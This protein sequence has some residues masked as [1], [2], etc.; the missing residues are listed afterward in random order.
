VLL[1]EFGSAQKIGVIQVINEI[2]DQS[3]WILSGIQSA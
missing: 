2:S 3:D 1:V